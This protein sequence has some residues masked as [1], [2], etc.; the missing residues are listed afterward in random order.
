MELIED[1]YFE[2]FNQAFEIAKQQNRFSA[3]DCLQICYYDG[4]EQEAAYKNLINLP[5]NEI[6]DKLFLLN[7]RIPT[8]IISKNEKN[9]LKEIE[10]FKTLKQ[11]L[12]SQSIQSIK[13]LNIDFNEPIR[14]YISAD[15]GSCVV[16]K[17]YLI[18]SKIFEKYNFDVYLDI[19]DE[20]T[21]MDDYRRA[22]AISNFNP[23]ITFNIN[24]LR[25]EHLYPDVLNFIWFMDPTL[26]LF[27]DSEIKLRKR[28]YIFYIGDEIY[29]ALKN[30]K[31]PQNKIFH[32]FLTPDY[33]LFKERE[34]IDRENKIVFIGQNY[35]EVMSP[36]TEYK[37]HPVINEIRVLF[38]K[39]A[40]TKSNLEELGHKY[41][42][43]IRRPEHLAIFIVPAVARE[44]MVKW[45]CNQKIIKSEVYGRGWEQ[46][47]EVAPYIKGFIHHE[48][49]LARIMN[50]AK[51]SLIPHSNFIFIPKL[52]E[53]CSCGA[54][55]IVYKGQ[56]TLD[57]FDK[58]E[59]NALIFSSKEE[60]VN[61]L[62]K[63][64]LKSSKQISNDISLDT[65]I[66]KI[67][68]ILSK[69]LS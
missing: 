3:Y 43:T 29:N 14:V 63:E 58:Y 38:N 31:V 40:L 7:T 66:A 8:K 46:V 2:D 16:L 56:T 60:F 37:N 53:A 6:V 59:N 57:S 35:F 36:T 61:L 13:T 67:N 69:E 21:L 65:I 25:N 27:D 64:P 68:E 4:E 23:H 12:Y 47:P 30:K 39:N 52:F 50:S 17:A 10:R 62:S 55:P 20:L 49:E 32:Q 24:R 26:I 42:Q 19:N 9:I 33:D 41:A 28:D 1:I 44:E 51:Y 54:I 34:G 5:H 45:M 15:F 11:N 48:D 18:L 22:K